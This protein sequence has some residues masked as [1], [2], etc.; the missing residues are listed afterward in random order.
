MSGDVTF[1]AVAVELQIAMS[2]IMQWVH[3]ISRPGTEARARM[4]GAYNIPV[5]AWDVAAGTA[6]P[7]TVKS[8]VTA[9][10]LK[11]REGDF[12]RPTHTTPPP[13]PPP[14]PPSPVQSAPPP[15]PTA[16]GPRP[17][18]LDQ[19]LEVLDALR[20]AR[21]VPGLIAA[22]RIKLA[23]SE[24]RMLAL[25]T[26]LE[27]DAERTEDRLVRE[28]PEWQR[29]KRLIVRVLSAHPAA[30]KDLAAALGD[31]TVTADGGPHGDGVD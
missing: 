7:A 8:D 1:E 25:R 19:C 12:S 6:P 29:L 26:R 23:D 18:S 22:E 11:D 13:A 16:P 10:G 2:T 9:S 14:P 20:E 31:P 21:S 27:R 5:R 4:A 3:G 15:A 24:G 28:H 30:L 17:T